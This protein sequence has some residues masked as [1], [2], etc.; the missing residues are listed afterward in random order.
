MRM[1]LRRPEPM[2]T[3]DSISFPF[4]ERRLSSCR[5]SAK[6]GVNLLLGMLLGVLGSSG[7]L[8]AADADANFNLQLTPST[9]TLVPGKRAGF[10]VTVEPV[11]GFKAPVTLSVIA[12]PEGVTADFSDNPVTP[13][14]STLL[15]L[16]AT[17]DAAVGTFTL[18][19][20]ASGG[21]VTNSTSST[22]TV[23]FGLLPL[24]YGAVRGQVTDADTG[25][26]ITNASVNISGNNYTT[27]DATGHYSVTNLALNSDNMPRMNWAYANQNGYWQGASESFYAV[28]GTTAEANI[29]M[30]KK[31]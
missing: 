30:L 16:Q 8:Q 22:V 14:G 25:Q 11:N 24:C 18:D 7:G 4:E 21:G 5:L 12:L 29:I 6:S 1:S 17:A 3:H 27:T 10:L 31:A 23:N 26:A 20:T 2:R 19:I 28:C 13:P 15:N 9:V